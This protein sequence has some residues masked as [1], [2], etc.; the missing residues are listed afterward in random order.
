MTMSEGLKRVGMAVIGLGRAGQI[1]FT[2]VV[3]NSRIE[4]K[5]VIEQ[6]QDLARSSLQRYGLD[7]HIKLGRADDFE[8]VLRDKR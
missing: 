8:T 5:W 6:N 3:R 2:N 1:H 7:R 4:L